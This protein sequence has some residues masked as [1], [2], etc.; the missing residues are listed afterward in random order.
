MSDI[1]HLFADDGSLLPPH[2]WPESIAS[3]VS[4]IEVVPKNLGE[5]DEEGKPVMTEVHKIKLWDKNPAL[6]N[7]AKHFNLLIEKHQHTGPDG[8]PIR[9]A[10]VDPEKLSDNTLDELMSAR[11]IEEGE[12]G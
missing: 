7:M 1:R 9:V 2:S 5:Y 4:S 6:T 12:D 11:V 8:G 10:A 3:A